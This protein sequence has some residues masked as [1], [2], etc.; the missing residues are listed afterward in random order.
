MI[1]VHT[2]PLAKIFNRQRYCV[3]IFYKII[4]CEISSV[5]EVLML[6]FYFGFIFSDSHLHFRKKCAIIL[7]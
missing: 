4:N 3:Y 5:R 1:Y 2:I 6:S 7:M